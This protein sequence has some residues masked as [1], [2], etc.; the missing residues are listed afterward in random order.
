[1]RLMTRPT[2][3]QQL[4]ECSIHQD[5]TNQVEGVG[6]DG[7]HWL[8]TS[9]GSQPVGGGA[10]G[11]SPKAIYVFSPNTDFND[12]HE[13]FTFTI[14]NVSSSFF[15]GSGGF[16]LAIP[17]EPGFGYHIGA[18]FCVGSKV[19]VDHFDTNMDSVTL[20]LDNDNGALSFSHWIPLDQVQGQR[21]GLAAVNI[22]SGTLL[23]T[24]GGG[25][26]SQVFS[27]DMNGKL[28]PDKVLNLTTP[29][30]STGWVQGGA[31]TPEGHL[32]LS[33]GEPGDTPYQYIYCYSLLNGN[34]LAQIPVLAEESTQEMQGMC[35]GPMIR[36]GQKVEIHTV[37]LDQHTLSKDGIFLKS[38]G[39][40]ESTIV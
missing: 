40:T 36:N 37:L 7:S 38:F 4:T 32:Y 24:F 6:W 15:G 31:V 10:L 30:P 33:W 18:L 16:Q 9:N 34:L 23:T 13:L 28:L 17:G 2:G 8:F 20:V 29:M 27:H 39:A 1:M 26:I 5:W 11:S 14:A 3:F 22:F 25:T 21:V 19:F 12:G 35:Y